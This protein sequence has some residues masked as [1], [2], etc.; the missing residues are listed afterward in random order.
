MKT[1]AKIYPDGFRLALLD[2]Y[3]LVRGK[4]VQFEENVV[5]QLDT[6]AMIPLTALTR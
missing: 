2:R 1:F 5:L 3:A 4:L 6:G